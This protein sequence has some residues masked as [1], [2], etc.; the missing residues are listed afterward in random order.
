[1]G[2]VESLGQPAKKSAPLTHLGGEG[3]NAQHEDH[4]TD[5]RAETQGAADMDTAQ[6]VPMMTFAGGAE[7]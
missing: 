5:A 1:M 7:R 2:A 3:E 6:R 4:R